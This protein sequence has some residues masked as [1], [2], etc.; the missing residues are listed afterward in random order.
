M[1]ALANREQGR[2]E[3]RLDVGENGAVAV[4]VAALGIAV[5][6]FLLSA[7]VWWL[8]RVLGPAPRPVPEIA[9]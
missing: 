8:D 9:R 7:L 6:L 1:S 2:V 3:F 4:T 5:F